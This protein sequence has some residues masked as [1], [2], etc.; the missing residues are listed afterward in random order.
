M[1]WSGMTD[2]EHKVHTRE[3]ISVVKKNVTFYLS[4]LLLVFLFFHS[5]IVSRK[6]RLVLGMYVYR[7]LS[8]NM[9]LFGVKH[10]CI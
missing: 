2:I 6:S 1:C 3:E 9:L 10:S 4:F 8:C 7:Q 5:F